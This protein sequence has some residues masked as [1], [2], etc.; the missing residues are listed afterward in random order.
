MGVCVDA[1][2]NQAKTYHLGYFT[3]ILTLW[4]PPPPPPPPPRPSLRGILWLFTAILLAGGW[5]G[6]SG[7]YWRWLG[8]PGGSGLWLG[9]PGLFWV[10]WA[11]GCPG[12]SWV[13]LVPGGL[14][15]WRS[16]GLDARKMPMAI[17]AIYCGRLSARL[18]PTLCAEFSRIA[19]I[20]CTVAID[21][22]D[23]GVCESIAWVASH[24]SAE[25]EEGIP[26]RQR[27]Y[28]R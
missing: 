3:Y 1:C 2:K 19:C 17:E 21:P 12:L 11:A 5:L 28:K 15:A 13:V 25:R 26:R 4:P 24:G 10:V 6:G 16:A 23:G 14:Q 8:D 20:G 9:G 22:G 7:G 18:S 27:I